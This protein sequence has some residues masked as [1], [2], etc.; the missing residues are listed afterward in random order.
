M[1]PHLLPDLKVDREI[2]PSHEARIG[3][4]CSKLFNGL[5][6]AQASFEVVQPGER[7][8]VVRVELVG[9]AGRKHE[10]Q[11]FF[12]FFDDFQPQRLNQKVEFSQNS[13]L[14]LSQLNLEVKEQKNL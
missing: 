13:G 6:V 5:D 7:R 2:P 11:I 8:R 10:R 9:V 14:E 1:W 3:W 4:I 12:E